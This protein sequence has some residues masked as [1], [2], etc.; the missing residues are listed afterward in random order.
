[1]QVALSLVFYRVGQSGRAAEKTEKIGVKK[2]NSTGR[3]TSRVAT[4][5]KKCWARVL[6]KSGPPRQGEPDSFSCNQEKDKLSKRKP[7]ENLQRKMLA[8]VR[9]SSSLLVEW[10]STQRVTCSY[11]RRARPKIEN[12]A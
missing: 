2:K 6:P 3:E 8:R 10:A 12:R 1:M 5:K 7:A 9:P 4:R 11:I